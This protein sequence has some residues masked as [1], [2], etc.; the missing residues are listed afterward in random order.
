MTLELGRIL[1]RGPDIAK[2]SLQHR[3]RSPLRAEVCPPAFAAFCPHAPKSALNSS[4]LFSPHAPKS[5]LPQFT[6]V[7]F[8]ESTLEPFSPRTPNSALQQFAVVL[9]STREVHLNSSLPFSPHAP[10]S[11]LQ[12]FAAVLPSRAEVRPPAVLPSRRSP[13]SSRSPLTR[14]IPPPSRAEV[15]PPTV[16]CKF[17]ASLMCRNPVFSS[18]SPSRSEQLPSTLA[19]CC[20]PQDLQVSKSYAKHQPRREQWWLVSAHQRTSA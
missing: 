14:R 13:P 1:P 12:Q 7:L 11:A 4:L 2:I 16:R 20:S 3:C 17:S 9:S 6:A 18:G 15:R 10:K 8:P 5:A 19:L